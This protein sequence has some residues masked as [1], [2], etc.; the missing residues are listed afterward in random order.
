[1]NDQPETDKHIFCVD[2]GQEFI[3]SV[4]EQ[5][6]FK[7][8]GFGNTPKRCRSCR[9]QRREN[10]QVAKPEGGRKSFATVWEGEKGGNRR[11]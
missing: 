7:E 8:K 10:G 6:V 9:R 11:G 5:K 1:M 4:G 2:C 3:W